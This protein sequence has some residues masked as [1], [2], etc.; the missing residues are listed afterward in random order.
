[1]TEGVEFPRLSQPSCASD[2]LEPSG[3]RADSS[4]FG[5]RQ[6]QKAAQ[7]RSRGLI[8]NKKSA[9]SSIREYRTTSGTK[10]LHPDG[11]EITAR[12]VFHTHRE[13]PD[14]CLSLTFEALYGLFSQRAWNPTTM[15]TMT[16]TWRCKCG[17]TIKVIAEF[18][19]ATVHPTLFAA[20]PDCG[21][22][23]MIYGDRIISVTSEKPENSRT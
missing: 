10:F 8:S 12:I 14:L 17:A 16:S 19:M 20:C 15:S 23:Q 6:N 21:D 22:R 2:C 11:I 13:W 5:F 7:V 18:D 3:G 4:S 9:A 1:V